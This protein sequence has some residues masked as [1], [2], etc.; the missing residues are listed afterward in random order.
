MIDPTGKSTRID[1]A[2]LSGQIWGLSGHSSGNSQLS[3]EQAN[4]ITARP[5]LTA[6]Q[7]KAKFSVAGR[8]FYFKV[9]RRQLPCVAGLMAQ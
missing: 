5:G 2:R 9:T 8:R 1:A 6:S 3:G 7:V 4:T